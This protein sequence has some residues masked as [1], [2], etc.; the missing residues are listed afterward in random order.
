MNDEEQ[1][2]HIN[3]ILGGHVFFFCVY[4][5]VFRVEVFNSSQ[6]WSGPRY[7]EFF[8]WMTV[9]FTI[10][11]WRKPQGEYGYIFLRLRRVPGLK[12]MKGEHGMND[13]DLHVPDKR[14]KGHLGDV[15]RMSSQEKYI[16]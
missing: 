15:Q 10:S 14:V 4:V 9:I 16:L 2:I 6:A 12:A 3:T 8:T 7:L 5:G 11:E 13:V 1:K